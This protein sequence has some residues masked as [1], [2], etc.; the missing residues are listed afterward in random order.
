MLA[1]ML[2]NT[3][4]AELD[5]HFR[6]AATPGPATLR[7]R[8]AL[9]Q[10]QGAKVAARVATTVVPQVRMA[11]TLGGLA[12][13]TA[14]TVG[15]ASAEMEVVDSTTGE[16]LAAAVDERA[17]TKAL[18]AERAYTQW[19][20]V[21]AAIDYW[22]KRMAWQL[23]RQGVQRKPGVAMPAEPQPARSL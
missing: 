14:G 2:Y 23:A 20:D 17:G 22:S 5:K 7:V 1:N 11:T 18:F 12:T 4:H 8:A 6:L 13:D 16:R 9:T 3:L 10:A 15:A 19:G 21:Q